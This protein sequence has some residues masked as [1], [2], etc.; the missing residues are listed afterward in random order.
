MSRRARLIETLPMEIQQNLSRKLNLNVDKQSILAVFLCFWI[1]CLCSSNNA[2]S[3]SDKRF[4]L[5]MGL[6]ILVRRGGAEKAKKVLEKFYIENLDSSSKW[7]LLT[8][9]TLQISGNLNKQDVL[10]S[11]T[12]LPKSK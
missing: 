6:S 2:Q 3:V 7:H 8:F 9:S 11:N 12:L 4:F 1:E 5:K 10:V